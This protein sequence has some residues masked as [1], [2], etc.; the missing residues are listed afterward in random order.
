MLTVSEMEIQQRLRTAQATSRNLT[1]SEKAKAKQ[2]LKDG[3][4]KKAIKLVF[5]CSYQDLK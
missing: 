3:Y 4:S 2:F 1:S 5:G